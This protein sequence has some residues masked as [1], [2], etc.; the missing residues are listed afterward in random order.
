MFIDVHTHV[1]TK[2][3]WVSYQKK[4]NGQVAK[5]ISLAWCYKDSPTEPDVERLLKFVATESNIYVA[6]SINM[7]EG[8]G[9]QLKRHEELFQQKKIVAIKLYPGYQHFYPYEGRVTAIAELCARYNKPLIF[10]SGDFYDVHGTALLEYARSIHIDQLARRCPNTKIV[11]SHF[12]F[13][14]F[15]DTAGIVS[16]HDHVYT[17]ISG[18]IDDSGLTTKELTALIEQYI[19]DLRRVFNYYP[20][21]KNKIMFG[22]DFVGEETPLKHVEP[23]R[24]VIQSLFNKREQASA[25]H[26]L[27]EK[28]YFAE[29]KKHSATA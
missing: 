26:E 14:H 16:Q 8:F 5:I 12:G 29:M 28:L 21:I 24:C 9:Q 1:S 17:D 18:T 11:I 22:T 19:A 2:E 13:P 3:Q 10:H 15:L 27:A 23:Y 6:G 4:S 20:N 7:D 25:F